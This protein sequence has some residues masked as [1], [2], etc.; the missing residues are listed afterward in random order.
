MDKSQ[1]WTT[2]RL[3][4]FICKVQLYSHTRGFKNRTRALKTKI[5]RNGRKWRLLRPKS[6]Y[7]T[8]LFECRVDPKT[9]I[10]PV[11][12]ANYTPIAVIIPDFGPML[13]NNV[14]RSAEMWRKWPVNGLLMA[15]VTS[16]QYH[17]YRG[18]ACTSNTIFRIDL[19]LVTITI[20]SVFIG[21]EQHLC[22]GHVSHFS[23]SRPWNR[24]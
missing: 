1:G 15:E 19:T 9:V 6:K 20:D 21:L 4:E 22:T 7:S 24:N 5:R 13:S 14:S 18:G 2:G 17:T 16:D 8:C 12:S 3:N 10:D 23:P 11:R